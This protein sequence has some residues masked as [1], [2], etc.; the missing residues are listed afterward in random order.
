MSETVDRSARRA[1]LLR[2][3]LEGGAAPRPADG[4]GRAPR[5]GPLPLSSAQRRLW[6][7]DRMRPGGT[8]YLMTAALHLRGPLDHRALHTALD[9]LPARHEV[10]RTRYPVVGDEPVQL[11]DE[12]SPVPLDE[13]DLRELDRPAAEARID[14]LTSSERRPVDLATG[15]VLRATL[16]RLAEDEHA[17]L[18]TFHHIAADGWSEDLLVTEFTAR[19]AAACSG[20]PA[21]A[22]PAELQYADYAVWQRERLAGAPS[23]RQLA[24]WRDRL[25][26]LPPLELPTD[27]P[28][29]PVWD[30]AGDQVPVAVPADT[31]GRLT[32]LAREHGAT[33]FMALLA[34]YAVLL[35]RWSGQRDLAVGTPVA[36]RD[37]A[38]LQSMVG[39]FLNTLVLRTDLSGTP[40]FTDL[41]RRVRE[42]AMDAYAHQELPFELLVDELVPERDPSRNPLFTTMLLWEDAATAGAV[43]AGGLT[44]GRLPV[45]E[46]SAK[47][48]LTLGLTEQPDGSLAGGI[49]YASA[50][51][52]RAT[53]ERFAAQL[54]RLLESAVAAPG[55]PVHELDV[56][57]PAERTLLLETWNDT[58]R[59]YPAGT[60]TALVEAQARRVPDAPALRGQGVTVSYA[61]LNTRANRLAHRLRALGVGPESVVGVRLHRGAELVVALLGV[62]KAGGAYLPLDPEYPAERL[63]FML[64]DSGARVVIGH[65][66]QSSAGAAPADSGVL[67]VDIAEDLSGLPTEDPAPLCEPAHPAYVIYTSGSTGR[68]KGVVVEHRAITNRL[69]WM[70]EA[71]RLGPDDR[72][73][74]KTPTGFDVSVWELFWPLVTGATMV[75]A[76]PG[77]HR[78][79]A[80]LAELIAGE[81]V[82]T[83]HFVPSMLREFL[84]GELPPLP[85]LR[86]MVC[87]GEALPGELAEAVHRRIGCELHN[88]YGPTEAAVDVTA[89][90]CLPGETVTIG[91]PIANTRTYLV[92]ADLRPVPI[93]VAGELLLGGVQ[94]ARGYLARPGL[95]A[96]RFV[97]SPFAT[98]PGERLYRTGDRARLRPDGA[99]EYLGRLDDQV[100]IRGQRVEPGEIEEALASA[101]GVAAAAVTVHDGRLVAHLAPRA[102]DAAAVREHLHHRLPAQLH[103]AHWLL[104][105]ALPLTP[106]GKTDRRALP[107]P[108]GSRSALA[109]EYV[110]PGD[111]LEQ[112]LAEAFAGALGLDR[113][114]VRDSFFQLGGDSMRAIRVVG[115][116][117]ERGIRL[118]VHDL[119]THQRVGELAALVRAADAAGP[120][121]GPGAGPDDGPLVEPFALIGAEDRERLPDG[122]ADAYP[123]AQTQAGMVF[124]MLAATDRAVYQ[125]VSC[126]RVRDEEPFDPDTLREAGRL[127]VERHEILRTTVDLSGY[128]QVLQLVHRHAELPVRT[129]DLRG[130][131]AADQRALVDGFLTAE[132]RRPFDLAT[133]PLLR[134]AVHVI[135]DHEWWLTHTECH[136]ILDG[137]SHTSVVAELIALYRA[138]RQG[139]R[140]DL[141]PPPDVRFADFV[142]LELAALDS[143]EDR[144]FWAE[145]IGRHEKFEL[146]PGWAGSEQ[147]ERAHIVDVDH[148]DLLPGL[149]RLAATAGASLKSVLHTAHL[150][151]LGVATGRTRFFTG[152]VTNGRPERARG[153]E[154]MGL[155]LNTVPFPADLSAPTWRALVADVF[156]GEAELW[157]HRRYP[158]P[159]MRREWGADAPLVEAAFGYLDFHVLDWESGDIGMV[160]DF[161]PSE[162]GLEV[163]TFPG[164]LR[165]GA[166][167]AVVGRPQLALLGRVYR[168]VLESMAA[169]PEADPRALTLPP[170][171]RAAALRAGLGPQAPSP[172]AGSVHELVARQAR[173]TPHATALRH[174]EETVGYAELERRAARLAHRLRTLGVGPD[175]VV[176][177][178]LPRTPDL[179]TAQLAVLKA[180]GAFLPLDPA[181][182]ADRLRHM[183]TDARAAVLLTTRELRPTLPP[184]APGT[185]EVLDPEAYAA[186]P[187]YAPEGPTDPESLAYLIYTSGSTG[188]PKGVGVPHRAAL[189]LR[190]AQC[191]PLDVRPGDRVLQYASPSFDA[192]VWELL[193]TLTHGA[194][195][196]LPPPDTD[197]GDLRQQSA[198]VTHMTVPPSLLSQ[199][200]PADFPRLRV[201]VSAGEACSAAQAS[202]WS[203]HATFVNAYG[204]TET[205]VCATLAPVTAT[206]DDR[207]PSIGGPIAGVSAYVLDDGLRP[208]PDGVRGE[209]YVG[210][211]GVARGYLNRPAATAAAFVPDPYGGRPGARLYRTGDLVSR[212][213]DGTLQYHGRRDHQVKVRGLRIEPGEI[214]ELLL[215]HPDVAAAAVTVHRGA[216]PDATLVAYT[217][218]VPGRTADPAGLRE[219]LRGRLPQALLPTHYLAVEEFPLNPAG[220]VD[221]AA[222]PAPDALR[223]QLGSAYAAPSTDLERAL[224]EAWGEALGVAAVGVHDDFFD[225]GGHSLAMMRIVATLRARHGL[226]LRFRSF[227]ENRTVARLA[228][229][230]ESARAAEE[231]DTAEGT[232]GALVWIREG[233]TGTPLFCVHPGGGSA[234]W[235]LRLAPHLDPDLPVAAFEWPGPHD[236]PTAPGAEEMAERYLA[237]LRRAQPAGPYR[238][239]SWCGGSGIASELAHRLADAGEEVTF[240][241]LD[242]GLDA[243]RRAEGWREFAL[244]QRLEQL[245]AELARGGAAADTPARRQ[246]ILELLDHLVDDVDEETGITLPEEGIGE[247]WPRE[248]RIWREVMEMDLAY[249]HRPF[250]LHLHL[251]AS[252]ELAQGRHE[253]SYGQEFADYVRRWGELATGGV[254]VHRIGGDHFGVM[255][256]P[257]VSDLAGV[258]ERV[259]A[260]DARE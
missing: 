221:R 83:L 69:H 9:A 87:S 120:D 183:L 260:A 229:E 176:G 85:A 191:G 151:A 206:G 216:G 158:M 74:H 187:P 212:S 5:T 61:E 165:L 178:H 190:Q 125:N 172:E 259:I 42:G 137:W 253:V 155:Y 17:L 138:L 205:A 73:L 40:S 106:S 247:V 126:Y 52:D 144:A 6:I 154:V 31:A 22:P 117:R 182:P 139:K 47:V 196:V 225:L 170:A 143:A 102:V 23:E 181:Y 209:L 147:D 255:K 132:R 230:L 94:L 110:A 254:T 97:P 224:C 173:R 219:H 18:L 118:A 239:F 12:P 65:G 29:P 249:R 89:V 166:R 11:V 141:P 231:T 213:A 80:Y 127:L 133:A 157:P 88:L 237:E 57:P 167:P 215:G 162:L 45:G 113:V 16:A 177:L 68:P 136:A 2:R 246:E 32:A 92:D 46:S 70:Q 188:R 75:L 55:L 234:H 98:A 109:G 242:P 179:V 145:R 44:V 129:E 49:T 108:D 36:G 128:S 169:D 131:P 186:L 204:P 192:Y 171:D 99:I 241:L 35:S 223:P 58:A 197:P 10:L 243:H 193:M 134:Y 50:L 140:P 217:R 115:A 121:Q 95:T 244:I 194:E 48:D 185:V 111:A 54:A 245:T 251:I 7:L 8:A 26:G 27:R 175:T 236:S 38:E 148:E 211:D 160:D 13:L 100:K 20:E 93:G 122:L 232:G 1:E 201:V 33:P 248:A 30:S 258:I 51:F 76:K 39:L 62:L 24:F 59:G 64:A 90:R 72:I 207:P 112:T 28:R 19:Y 152:L 104:H 240:L 252:D 195:L 4:I 208:L 184:D 96:E 123:L 103:P 238:L 174:G 135:D 228:A 77:G 200:D 79:P 105:D 250:A 15:P 3:R 218:A 41:L 86:R 199:Q 56:L 53:V 159:A 114:G 21:A 203:R 257:Y 222:L 202:R 235:Y 116:L 149:R 71:Y 214:E 84:A 189:N 256:P 130:L 101:P 220:K 161:S 156:A 43:P 168:H 163:W 25:A 91:R 153:D 81:G 34:A 233:G 78:D 119:F 150:A 63:A 146:P 82:T 14:A 210:G 60:L 226:E 124:E 142:A 227:I 198:L 66:G 180:G 67:P 37:R 107:A 164:V